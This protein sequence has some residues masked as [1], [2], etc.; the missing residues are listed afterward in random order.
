MQQVSVRWQLFW[1]YGGTWQ[2]VKDAGRTWNV[3]PGQVLNDPGWTHETPYLGH[4]TTQL[5]ITWRT[6][7]GTFLGQKFADYASGRSP[8]PRSF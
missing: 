3:Y 6:S 4:F 2:L 8:R 7:T 1:T 5:T